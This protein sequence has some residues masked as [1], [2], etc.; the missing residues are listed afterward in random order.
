MPA[1]YSTPAI[2]RWTPGRF[3][4]RH[5][6]T[7]CATIRCSQPE[8]DII[9]VRL[10]F[11]L[12]WNYGCCFAEGTP[13]CEPEVFRESG[14]VT[15]IYKE[16]IRLP[17]PHPDR[18]QAQ[19]RHGL[20]AWITRVEVDVHAYHSEL[21]IEVEC[22]WWRSVRLPPGAPCHVTDVG[23]RPYL[24][25]FVSQRPRRW[26]LVLFQSILTHAS[27]DRWTAFSTLCGSL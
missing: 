7:R 18:C 24:A 14:P 27:H 25:S 2:T 4:R 1:R 21:S 20:R 3:V 17:E 6:P 23:R 13:I 16:V 26:Q 11:Y 22:V 9:G 10:I 5:H 15:A 19:R 8:T 12:W